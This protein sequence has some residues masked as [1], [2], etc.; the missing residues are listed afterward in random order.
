[1]TMDFK[2]AFWLVGVFAPVMLSSVRAAGANG[3][4]QLTL[5]AETTFSGTVE[6][7]RHQ[8]CEVCRCIEVS[9][10]LN[11]NDGRL[12]ARL[13]PKDFLDKRDLKISKGDLIR[14]TGLR[15]TVGGRDL[16]LANDVR[17][18]RKRVVLRGKYGRPKWIEAHGH[19]C[20]VC[21]N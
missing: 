12:E 14:V 5:P 11:T 8:E 20:P 19:T 3:I 21:G 2:W 10:I 17:K 9:V 7:V 16:M 18:G 6:E 1:M 15:F 13:G 4:G